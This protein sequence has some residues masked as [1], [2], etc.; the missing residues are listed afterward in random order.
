[1]EYL[2]SSQSARIAS[3]I[4]RESVRSWVR[5]RFLA[6]CWVSVEPPCDAAAAGDVAHH[7]PRDADRIDAEMRIEAPVLDR[8]EG[9]GQIGRQVDEPD[10]RAAGVAA[11]GDQR[12]VVGEDGDIGRA[13]G[14]RE[15]VDRRQLARLDR[16]RARRSAMT[17]QTPSTQLQ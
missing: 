15:L 14:H 11:I 9:L 7:R 12:A 5:N 6:S 3:W 2:R 4:L 13:L 16:R 17:P 1:M 8:D 10:R